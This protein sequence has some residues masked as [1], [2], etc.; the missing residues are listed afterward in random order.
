[1]DQQP[2]MPNLCLYNLDFTWISLIH[3]A[4]MLFP[5]PSCFI[6][7]VGLLKIKHSRL[8]LESLFMALLLILGACDL[9]KTKMY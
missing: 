6:V 4:F 3:H 1:M 7:P 5:H 8:L 9:S 2:K